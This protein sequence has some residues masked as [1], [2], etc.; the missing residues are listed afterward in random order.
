MSAEITRDLRE[1]QLERTV[2][3]ERVVRESSDQRT[4]LSWSDRMLCCILATRELHQE[5]RES[6]VFEL[7]QV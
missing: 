2:P 1:M 6:E 7:C 5:M 4:R 3:T